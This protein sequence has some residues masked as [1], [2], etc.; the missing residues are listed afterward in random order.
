MNTCVFCLEEGD[1]NRLL[2]HNVKCR[3]NYCFHLVCYQAYTNKS[4]C[5]LCRGTVGELYVDDDDS[6]D[7]INPV[8]VQV[9]VSLPVTA[10]TAVTTVLVPA[11]RPRNQYRCLFSQLFC[12]CLCLLIITFIILLVTKYI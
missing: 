1:K 10:V 11:V 4:V 12:I 9:P 7:T 2:L 3:C 8:T 6:I 5:P